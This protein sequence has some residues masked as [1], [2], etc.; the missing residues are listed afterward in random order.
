M[1][2]IK[3]YNLHIKSSREDIKSLYLIIHNIAQNQSY[4][5]INVIFNSQKSHILKSKYIKRQRKKLT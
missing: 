1:K 2:R 5:V 4:S 3:N